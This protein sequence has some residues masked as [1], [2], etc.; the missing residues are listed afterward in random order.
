MAIITIKKTGYRVDI[1]TTTACATVRGAA[2]KYLTH[3]PDSGKDLER[4]DDKRASITAEAQDL[5]R[6]ELLNGIAHWD[7]I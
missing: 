6:G 4:R 7:F 3:R 1:A 2:G 5:A